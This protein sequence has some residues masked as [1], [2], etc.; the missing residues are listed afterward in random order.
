M[1]F[2]VKGPT[3]LFQ[4][5]QASGKP[6]R[7]PAAPK[8]VKVIDEINQAV[9]MR[10]PRFKKIK[11]IAPVGQ[12]FDDK[13][14]DAAVRSEKRD[15]QIRPV[16]SFQG[17]DDVR[18]AGERP[19]A[20]V[21]ETIPTGGFTDRWQALADEWKTARETRNQ[22]ASNRRNADRL[23]AREDAA[24]AAAAAAERN[25]AAAAATSAHNAAR[26]QA[27]LERE[28][29]R[30]ARG[31]GGP[32]TPSRS[33]A[34]RPRRPRDRTVR[35]RGG[36]PD[37]ADFPLRDA[38]ENYGEHNLERAA[39]HIQ[40]NLLIH[41]NLRS[42]R[43]SRYQMYEEASPGD[44]SFT[45]SART[46]STASGSTSSRHSSARPRSAAAAAAA[47]A[48]LSPI[49]PRSREAAD[50]LTQLGARRPAAG[51]GHVAARDDAVRVNAT[52]RAASPVASPPHSP[53]ADERVALLEEL[54]HLNTLNTGALPETE[55]VAVIHRKRMIEERLSGEHQNQDRVL[56]QQRM[57]GLRTA[58][59]HSS[60]AAILRAV[61]SGYHYTGGRFRQGN[62]YARPPPYLLDVGGPANAP[63]AAPAIPEE[64]PVARH[65]Q[66]PPVATTPRTR[67]S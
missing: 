44:I 7:A 29:E 12:K 21:G 67:R 36:S 45:P 35:A 49:S 11:E 28:R 27:R 60:D 34:P 6:P 59:P 63:A 46:G 53:T 43:A 30:A 8:S 48:G 18:G 47:P 25:A 1:A 14:V 54:L 23:A 37:A 3:S 42:P 22:E 17:L 57:A 64:L 41:G 9:G 55:K 65:N 10:A 62:R 26:E 50:V 15:D 58:F 2:R 51:A 39:G 20:S 40:S 13:D 4:S 5:R 61:T 33:S 31:R 38:N 19:G 66:P 16:W 56:E 32:A 24:A 52:F